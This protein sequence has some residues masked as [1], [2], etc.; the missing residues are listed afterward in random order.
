MQRCESMNA[1][2]NHFLKSRLKLFEFVNN[3]DRT[4]SH[5]FHNEANAKFETHHSSTVLTT[6][7]YALEKHA[8]IV[9]TRQSFHKF[10]D[11]MKNAKLFFP[12]DTKNHGGYHVHPLTKFRS[13]DKFWKVCY[14]NG[15][16]SM[17]CTCIMFK[18]ID[19]SYPHMIVVM[20]IEHLE[21]IPE[22][23][24]MKRWSK[25]AKEMV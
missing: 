20:K 11:E 4:L 3:F 5:I 18:S 14:G 8:E 21:E 19:F 1:Y 23:C 10:K 17:K 13:L 2:L 25:L 12:V 9:F 15:D 6:K 24:I 22:S 16:Q 7:L